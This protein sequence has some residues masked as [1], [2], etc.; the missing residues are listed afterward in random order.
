MPD[1]FNFTRTFFPVNDC[2]NGFGLIGTNDAIVVVVLSVLREYSLNLPLL[3]AL[4]L[5]LLSPN[6]EC[7]LCP[8]YSTYCCTTLWTRVLILEFVWSCCRCRCR[9][10]CLS[11]GRCCL[12]F[13]GKLVF[14]L[15]RKNFPSFFVSKTHMQKKRKK[16]Y[17]TLLLLV[18]SLSHHHHHHH[19]HHHQ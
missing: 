6:K 19:H 14:D 13:E 12:I 11:V 15:K 5:L 3:S 18:C 7:L 17:H 8:M 1:H 4:L 10:R 16:I 2:K 9:C